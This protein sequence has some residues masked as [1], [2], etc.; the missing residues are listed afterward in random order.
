MS[1]KQPLILFMAVHQNFT[2]IEFLSPRGQYDLTKIEALKV[3]YEDPVPLS[4]FMC[5]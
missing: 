1:E 4:E 3:F 5:V 2:P